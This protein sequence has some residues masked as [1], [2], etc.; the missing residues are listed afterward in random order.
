MGMDNWLIWIGWFCHSFFV[1]FI[2][3]LIM[4]FFLKLEV[5]YLG[6]LQYIFNYGNPSYIKFQT[7]GLSSL[8]I[9][10]T[11]VFYL[12][13]NLSCLENRHYNLFVKFFLKLQ[14]N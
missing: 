12:K 1:I 13:L 7:F 2:I 11:V 9:L 5:S 3:S 6:Y 4:I 14:V 8:A 10:F